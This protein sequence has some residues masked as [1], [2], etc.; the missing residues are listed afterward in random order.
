MIRHTS[1]LLVSAGLVLAAALPA[2]AQRACRAVAGPHPPGTYLVIGTGAVELAPGQTQALRAGLS[3]N[4]PYSPPDTLPRGCNA[5]WRVDAGAPARI[6]KRGQL[7]VRADAAPGTQFLVHAVVGRDTARQIVYVVDPRPNPL[8]GTW[9]ETAPA[10]C[11]PAAGGLEPVR[12]LVFRRN[13]RFTVTFMPFETYNDYWGRYTYDHATGALKMQIERGNRV[14][15]DAD[16]EGTA[17]VVDK[18]LV[19]EGMWLGQPTSEQPRT[20]TYTF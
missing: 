11:T 13:G 10:R 18:H 16:L 12:E 15:P 5:R 14:P 2:G 19:L 3:S 1:I 6:D 4:P 9:G 20:C 17:R 8:A 7:A